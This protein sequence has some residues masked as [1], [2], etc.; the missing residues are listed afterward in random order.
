M[1]MDV[2]QLFSAMAAFV[3]T[4]AAFR[5]FMINRRKLG[6][7]LLLMAGCNAVLAVI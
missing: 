1:I 6:V 7:C 3:A 5:L 4:L 2:L